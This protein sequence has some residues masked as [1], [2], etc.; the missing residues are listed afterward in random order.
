MFTIGAFRDDDAKRLFAG[1]PDKRLLTRYA[2]TTIDIPSYTVEGYLV[3]N[4]MPLTLAEF[5]FHER[6]FFKEGWCDLTIREPHTWE[7]PAFVLDGY[8]CYHD[9]DRTS[10][11]SHGA[12]FVEMSDI[13]LNTFFERQ[14]T[15]IHY[16]PYSK[17]RLHFAKSNRK[18][19]VLQH[20]FSEFIFPLDESLGG[21]S[22]LRHNLVELA[23][24]HIR[25]KDRLLFESS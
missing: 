23:L 13:D 21:I 2:K 17:K 11:T 4:A 5:S 20:F 10:I 18:P 9:P 25:R 7:R 8:S 15:V 24:C 12:T 1:L 19:R 22:L 16:R 14:V 3:L 6:A